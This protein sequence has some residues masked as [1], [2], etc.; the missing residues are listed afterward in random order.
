MLEFDDTRFNMKYITIKMT[1]D[2]NANAI[3]AIR[4]KYS[5]L[6]TTLLEADETV[7]FLPIN[8]K[9][10]ADPLRLDDEIPPQNDRNQYLLSFNFEIT[11]S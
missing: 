11:K 10:T 9:K 4:E 8:P 2:T 5:S 1:L 3:E 6:K 7:I